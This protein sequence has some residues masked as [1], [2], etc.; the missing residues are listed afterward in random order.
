M[1]ASQADI[2]MLYD[3][4]G[5]V[6]YA[7]CLSILKNPE[8]A[9]D[10]VQDTF[11]K[12]IVGWDSFQGA[13]SPLTWM[14]RISTNL[15]LNRLRNRRGRAD[16]REQHR[17]MIV[18][19]GHTKPEATTWE[20]SDTVRALLE[21]EDP[22]TQAIVVH[23]YFDEMTKEATAKLVGIS[24][25]TL[26]KRLRAFQERARQ[27]VESGAIPLAAAAGLILLLLVLP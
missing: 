20:R 6:L 19:E 9:G 26:R 18:G 8:D 14:Y 24:V 17:D 21:R 3:R 4:Y 16:K 25:P 23:L 1:P 2:Q 27:H 10:A 22:E 5:Q 11:A 7:R 15:C 12:V 13:S